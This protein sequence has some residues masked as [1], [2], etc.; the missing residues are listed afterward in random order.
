ME[1]RVIAAKDLAEVVTVMLHDIATSSLAS[2]LTR[3]SSFLATIET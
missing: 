3:F 1:R 2:A